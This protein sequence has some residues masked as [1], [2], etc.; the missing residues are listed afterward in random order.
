MKTSAV[1]LLIAIGL[2]LLLGA[3]AASA[4]PPEVGA[5]VGQ[6]AFIG[7]GE[8]TLD[9]GDST[10]A[11][12]TGSSAPEGTW[13]WEQVCELGGA[14]TCG[15][16]AL[17]ADGKPKLHIWY[18]TEAGPIWGSTSCPEDAPPGAPALPALT[19]PRIVREFQRIPLPTATI[20]VA[21]PDG[22]TLVNLPTIYYAR[23]AERF[24][25][26]VSI[27][28]RRVR[29][30][31][32]PSSYQWDFG[33]GLQLSSTDPGRAYVHGR[34]P[35]DN[36]GLYLTARYTRPGEVTPSLTVEWTATYSIDGGP[37]LPV[38]ATVTMS[39]QGRSVE[40]LSATPVLTGS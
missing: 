2:M 35:E 6:G 26:T 11:S 25:R 19:K 31:I 37:A 12:S 17:C 20:G 27:L 1:P 4:D 3:E 40:V 16:I 29:F 5:G 39:S 22:R 9:P 13:M 23:G 34:T 24:E 21:P 38:P 36:P 10:H 18:Q 7:L 30:D 8:Q 33:Q 28:G 14:E 15:E 32:T